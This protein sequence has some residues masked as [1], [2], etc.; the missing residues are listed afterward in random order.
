MS[1]AFLLYVDSIRSAAA[2]PRAAG[3]A[4]NR[5]GERERETETDIDRVIERQFL[6]SLPSPPRSRSLSAR[7][8]IFGGS[9]KAAAGSAHLES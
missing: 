7:L 1:G 3:T 5:M 4:S 6:I 9:P 8:I 2:T